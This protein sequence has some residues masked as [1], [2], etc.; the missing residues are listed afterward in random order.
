MEDTEPAIFHLL[1]QWLYSQKIKVKKDPIDLLVLVKLWDL[2]DL[3]LM[4][5]L[6]NE[7]VDLTYRIINRWQQETIWVTTELFNYL[8]SSETDGDNS[9][10][11][12]CLIDSFCY[13]STEDSLTETMDLLPSGAWLDVVLTLKRQSGVKKGSWRYHK[14]THNHQHEESIPQ[15]PTSPSSSPASKTPGHI[16]SPSY[17]PSSPGF[18]GTFSPY[19]ACLSSP[20]YSPTPP[21]FSP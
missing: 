5:K 3:C 1:F 21:S 10:M 13:F 6:Q 14:K 19:F 4:P 2:A 9:L 7:V 11:K 20:S 16:P 12:L 18:Y 15:S 8:Y 17:L